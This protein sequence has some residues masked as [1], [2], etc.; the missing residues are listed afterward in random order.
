VTGTVNAVEPELIDLTRA[1]AASQWQ[2]L[3]RIRFPQ[4]LPFF[5]S[6]LKVAITLTVIGAVIAEFVVRQI[7]ALTHSKPGSRSGVYGLLLTGAKLA[8]FESKRATHGL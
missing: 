5:F 8:L 2:T 6:G 7:T 1:L 4:A 3:W